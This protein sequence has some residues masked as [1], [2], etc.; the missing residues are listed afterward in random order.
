MAAH[1][2]LGLVL[3]LQGKFTAARDHFEQA[4]PRFDWGQSGF[5]GAFCP[6]FGARARWA[7][8]YA[9][10]ALKWS[11]EALASAEARDPRP[12]APLANALSLVAVLHLRPPQSPAPRRSAPRRRLQ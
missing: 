12:A 6:C 9:D 7:L 10:Q 2:A 1:G 8:G 11:R 5:F 3:L 4:S